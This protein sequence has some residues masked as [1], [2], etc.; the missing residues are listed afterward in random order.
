MGRLKVRPGNNSTF[1]VFMT[2]G[3][4]LLGYLVI[5]RRQK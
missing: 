1:D 2:A 5:E 3:F 4:G